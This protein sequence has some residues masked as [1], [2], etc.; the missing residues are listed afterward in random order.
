MFPLSVV[1]EFSVADELSVLDTVGALLS[2]TGLLLSPFAELTVSEVPAVL[3]A[4]EEPLSVFGVSLELPA[5]EVPLLCDCA[6][7]L[8]GVEV[9]LP[10]QPV[11]LKTT[12]VQTAAAKNLFFIMLSW[13]LS[14]MLEVILNMLFIIGQRLNKVNTFQTNLY[15]TTKIMNIFFRL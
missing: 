12:A 6:G 13:F 3:L 8:T 15:Y 11:R 4:F 10:A 5:D 9:S 2:F 14:L 1:V 7:L